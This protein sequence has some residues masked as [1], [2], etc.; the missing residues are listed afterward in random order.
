MAAAAALRITS[1]P[2]LHGAA[3]GKRRGASA[4]VSVPAAPC[5]GKAAAVRCQRA[6]S[7]GIVE[8]KDASV[9]AAGE[10]GREG[11]GEEPELT[12]VMKFGGSSVASAERMREVAD[13]ILSFPEERP[14]VVLSAMGKTTNKLLMAGEKAVSCGATNVSELDELSF[15]KELHLGTL[16]QLGL[17]RSIV[18][19]L[20][21]ELEQL[22]KGI[23]MMKELTLRT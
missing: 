15:I 22:L 2:G 16:D 12:V 13:L 8:K 11:R 19:D 1:R 17:D 14:V 23:S 6:A 20:L 10:R 3:A 5:R 18:Y 9:S 21:D 4:P 7:G